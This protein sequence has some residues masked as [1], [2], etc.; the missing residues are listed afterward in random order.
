MDIMKLLAERVE[1]I[2]T[3]RFGLTREFLDH[4]QVALLTETGDA[5]AEV[6]DEWAEVLQAT[7]NTFVRKQQPVFIVTDTSHSTQ[8][9]TTGHRDRIHEVCDQAQVECV[10]G[11]VPV[12]LPHGDLE[13]GRG[14][15]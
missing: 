14:G 7:V 1:T 15:P 10:A 12:Q 4:G 6:L 3:F 5:T 9:L 8:G 13:G 2:E 11:V